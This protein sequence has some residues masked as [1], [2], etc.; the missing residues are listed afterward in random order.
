M[1]VLMCVA[2]RAYELHRR[3]LYVTQLRLQALLGDVENINR[4]FLMLP[5]VDPV[6]VF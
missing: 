3:L 6:V 5:N 2:A 4:F 1:L